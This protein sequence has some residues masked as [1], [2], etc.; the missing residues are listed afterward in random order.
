MSRM[1]P[2]AR[3]RSL[4]ARPRRATSASVRAFMARSE[5]RSSADRA[6]PHSASPAASAKPVASSAGPATGRA[7]RRAWNSHGDAHRSQ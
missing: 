5:R 3:F 7:L 6:R 1:P 2:A 4:A